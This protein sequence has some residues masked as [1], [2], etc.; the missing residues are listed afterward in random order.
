[1]SSSTPP[2]TDKPPSFLRQSERLLLDYLGLGTHQDLDKLV[3]SVHISNALE[4]YH[5]GFLKNARPDE[6]GEPD[7]RQ[8]CDIASTALDDWTNNINASPHRYLLGQDKIGWTPQD[9]AARFMIR[10]AHAEND[11]QMVIT[12]AGAYELLSFLRAL[13]VQLQI[14]K[15][16]SSNKNSNRSSTTR[17]EQANSAASK[18]PDTPDTDWV[19]ITAQMTIDSD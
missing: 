13:Y 2:T 19:D 12:C 7:K 8:I 3:K 15:E 18:P 14:Q 11:M 5:I 6:L 16:R 9:H 1:M 17:E 10:V 4:E